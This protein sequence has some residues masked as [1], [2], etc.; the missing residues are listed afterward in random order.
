[1]DLFAVSIVFMA[2]GAA[3]AP[4]PNQEKGVVIQTSRIAVGFHAEC[5]HIE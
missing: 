1:M 5:C 4:T 3:T 2:S